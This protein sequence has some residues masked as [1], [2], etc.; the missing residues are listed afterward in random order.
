MKTAKISAEINLIGETMNTDKTRTT[1]EA[2]GWLKLAEEDVFETGCEKGS[3]ATS[4]DDRFIGK[5]IKEVV[6]KCA[7][8]CPGNAREGDLMR[9]SCDEDGRLDIQVMEDADGNGASKHQKEQ[10]RQGKCRLWLC[11]YVFKIERVER[12]PIKMAQGE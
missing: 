1:Y 7:G 3:S 4:G 2:T 11:T 9:D 6:A 5:D 8:F 12:K 10:W